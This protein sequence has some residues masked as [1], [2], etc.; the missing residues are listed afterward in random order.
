MASGVA[1]CGLGI[2]AAASA[3]DLEFIPLLQERYDLV[4]PTK[5]YESELLAPLL[6]LLSDA[7]FRQAV[8]ELPGY[9]V[10]GMGEIQAEIG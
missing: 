10:D 3:L 4:I 7:G 8:A 2:R 5:N 1:D 6:G 9:S